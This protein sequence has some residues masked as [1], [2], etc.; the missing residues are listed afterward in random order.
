MDQRWAL[1][2]PVEMRPTGTDKRVLGRGDDSLW[3]DLYLQGVV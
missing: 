3:G 1:V 2:V